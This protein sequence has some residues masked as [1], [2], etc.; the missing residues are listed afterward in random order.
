MSDV[1]DRFWAKV[2]KTEGCWLW[3][4]SKRGPGYGQVTVAPGK[5]GYAHR[6][7]YEIH[8][9][10]IPDGA[11][12]DHTCHNKLCV[13]PSHLQPVT[14][15]QNMENRSGATRPSSSGVRGVHWVKSRNKWCAQVGHQG[16]TVHLGYFENL[17]EAEATVVEKRNELH[18]NNLLDR[19][20][21]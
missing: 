15:R 6:Y 10:P 16:E 12:I 3:T 1:S 14:I 19:K 18:T 9:G 2:L 13:R 21:S 4:A 17:S 8:N 20:A 11:H 5:Q 7:S